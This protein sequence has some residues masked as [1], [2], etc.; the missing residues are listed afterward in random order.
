M[1]TAA[2]LL[3]VIQWGWYNRHTSG[4][5]ADPDALCI[6]DTKDERMTDSMR[7]TADKGAPT[8]PVPGPSTSREGIRQMLA[9]LVK[10][11]PANE[12]AWLHLAS[13][14]RE[15]NER[16][17]CLCRVL[18]I[19]PRNRLAL[20]L[21]R[22]LDAELSVPKGPSGAVAV[23]PSL[24]SRPRP[25]WLSGRR[26]AVWFVT[27]TVFIVLAILA[28]QAWVATG[29]SAFSFSTAP[30]PSP[31][32][33]LT[34]TATA[35]P[36]PSVA[37][38]VAGQIPALEQ[39]W[40]ARDWP[41]AVSVLD[42]IGAI[43]GDYPG[44][45]SA[46]CDTFL[47]W[48]E[49]LVTQQ[50]VQQAYALYCRAVPVCD[51]TT[52]VRGRRSL[53]LQYLS[54]QWR[55]DHQQWAQAAQ[56]LQQVYDTDPDYVDTRALL[57]ASYVAWGQDQLAQGRLQTA[58]EAYEAALRVKPGDPAT[59]ASL[60]GIRARLGPNPTPTPAGATG[61]HIE[62]NLSEQRMYVWQGNT[63]L[64]TW[65]CSTGEPGRNT[66]VGRFRV[67]DKIPEAW[68]STW[69]LRMPYWLGIYQAGSLENGIHA[70]PILPN[71]KT[72]WE[73]YLGTP[74]SY[75]CVILSTENARTLYNWAEVG[76]PVWIHY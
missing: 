67:L 69:N 47:H 4:I 52:A 41:A 46:R 61:K 53:A 64:H 71:G 23:T 70:L 43:D 27:A 76:T 32:P 16:R 62:V 56:A 10:R 50:D 54:G 75:G 55:Y 48:A 45:A 26:F 34:P 8:N 38:R 25:R 58:S 21:L 5:P 20:R 63:L 31:V 12:R 29:S 22:Q 9:R 35:V 3:D 49:D 40:Q 33:T 7:H 11:E 73:G 42:R 28:A 14:T 18:R 51:D 57:H 30:T 39:A 60:D 6:R 65:V 15:P 68:A 17:Y 37:E 36:T 13:L 44:L 19:N 59:A 72:L 1:N 66:A 2:F 24:A 74:V